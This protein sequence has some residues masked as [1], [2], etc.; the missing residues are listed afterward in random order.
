MKFESRD[1]WAVSNV[2]NAINTSRATRFAHHRRRPTLEV[3]RSSALPPLI[4]KV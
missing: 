2:C 1:R 4:S 3:W